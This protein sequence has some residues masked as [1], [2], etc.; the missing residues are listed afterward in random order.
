MHAS[1][2]IIPLGHT[3]VQIIM[4]ILSLYGNHC[5]VSHSYVN[6]R[7][8][9]RNIFQIPTKLVIVISVSCSNRLNL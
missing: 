7:L 9:F 2:E 4:W 8:R 5:I 3:C 6:V 1:P